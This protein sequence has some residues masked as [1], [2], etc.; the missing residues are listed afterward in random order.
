MHS[1]ASSCGYCVRY[2]VY[3][4]LP[5]EHEVINLQTDVIISFLSV[6]RPLFLFPAG[7]SEDD[8]RVSGPG[9]DV[10]HGPAASCW[11]RAVLLH[12]GG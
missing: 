5:Y 8:P 6:L 9:G 2:P 11:P 12:P 3:F 1:C 10:E 4:P 7:H